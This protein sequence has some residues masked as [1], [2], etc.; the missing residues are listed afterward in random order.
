MTLPTSRTAFPNGGTHM[1]GFH[2]GVAA[3]V[4]AHL[5]K[6]RLLTETAPDLSPA[7]ITGGLTTVMS[8]KLDR[9]EPSGSTP[10]MPAGTAARASQPRPYKT[11]STQG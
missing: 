3:P 6:R 9:P 10:S 11:T 2:D 5:R 8:V 1:T 4:N 7:Q